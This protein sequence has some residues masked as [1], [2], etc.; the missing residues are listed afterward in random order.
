MVRLLHTSDWHLGLHLHGRSLIDDQA[1]ALDRLLDL[2]DDTQ[3]HALLISGD[4][5]DRAFPPEAAVSL[6]D[7]FLNEAAG[8]RRLPIVMIPGNHDSCERLGFASG[9]LRDRGVTIFSR[10]EDAFEPVTIHGDDGAEVSIHGI[11]FVEPVVIARALG[12]AELE[13]P[14]LAIGALCREI[15][16]RNPSKRPAVLLCHA[17]VA[18]GEC[19]DSERGIFIG[20]SSLVHARAFE[21]FAYTALGHLHK[22]QLA[23]NASVRYSGSLLPYSKSEIARDKS[24]YEIHIGASS[25]EVKPHRLEQLHR[26]RF[27]EGELQTLLTAASQDPSSDDYIFASYT[28]TGA[29]LDARAKLLAFYPNLLNVSRAQAFMPASQP[30]NTRREYEKVSELDLFADF[31][32]EATGS[33]LQAAEREALIEAIGELGVKE[34][35]L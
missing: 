28:D 21:G 1:F 33:E 17:F 34:R 23:G 32:Q 18:G 24:V 9:L 15:L 16:T 4:I 20:G 12:R 25:V 5:F 3:P 30:A 26:M 14:D 27:I 19:S 31:F 6:L 2:I 13:T 7:R 35:S 29:V 10:V 8:R 11:P 22:P